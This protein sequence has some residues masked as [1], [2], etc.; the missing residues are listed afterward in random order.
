MKPEG[1][2]EQI[3]SNVWK[4]EKD[5]CFFSV[6]QYEFSSTAL[7]VKT[8]HDTLRC[9]SFPHIVPV[10]PT[11]H[12]LTLMQPWL[13]GA[14]SVNFKRRADRTDSLEALTRL[15]E[16]SSL[17]NWSAEPYLHTYPLLAKWESRIESFRELRESCEVHI[18]KDNVDDIIFYATNAMRILRQTY[19]DQLDDTLLHGDVVHHNI[20]RD[21]LGIIRFIDFDLTCTGPAGTEIA[22]WIHRVLPQIDYD[23]E[24]LMNEQP[25]LQMLDNS[26]KSLLLY[27]NELLREWIYFFTLSEVAQERQVKI[28]IPFTKSALSHW[29]KLWYNVERMKK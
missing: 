28:L 13:E 18:G 27:P 24:F 4:L 22:L 15:H 10:L 8:I 21:N 23:I 5:G 9:L 29:P 20:L 19:T 12:N 7:K 16:T 2:I 3:N 14:R 17:I 6:K 26:S 25:S 1:N 11:D